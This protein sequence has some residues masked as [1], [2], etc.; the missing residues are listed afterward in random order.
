MKSKKFSLNK[1]EIL[2][3]LKNTLTFLAP[4]LLVFLTVI[5]SGG[6]MNEALISLYLWGLNTAIDLLK[7][8][9]QKNEVQ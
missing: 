8:F 4:A 2:K 7:K 6:T 9:I 5:Q 3:W 1:E